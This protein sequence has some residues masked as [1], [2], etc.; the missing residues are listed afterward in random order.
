MLE[1]KNPKYFVSK[2]LTNFFNA[3]E[4]EYYLGKQ[5]HSCQ[6]SFRLRPRDELIRSITNHSHRH[7]GLVEAIGVADTVL[8]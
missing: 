2:C 3:F 4:V 8:T 6:H 5:I 1:S 7:H